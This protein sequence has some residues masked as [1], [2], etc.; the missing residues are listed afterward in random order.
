VNKDASP[1]K[2][3]NIVYFQVDNLGQGELGCY[4]GG[5]RRGAVTQRIDQFARD[6]L[7]LWH[8][9]T[10]PQCTPSRS[11][12][13]TGR[14]PIRS[15]THTVAIGGDEGG[16]VAW[17]RTLGDV[18]SDAGYATS[19]VGKWHIGAEPGRYPTDHGFDEWYGIPRSYDECLW[20]EDPRYDPKRDPVVYTLEGT[21]ESGIHE[22]K[23]QQ[24]TLEVRRTIDVEYE[25]RAFAFLR[26]S[27]ESE[28]P[29]FL[30]YNH[31]MMHL[32]NIPRDEFKGKSGYG[33]FADCLL[34]MDADFGRLL[35]LLDELNVAENT[36]VIFAGDNGPE[37]MLLHRGSPGLYDGSYFTSSEGG[38]R[39]PCIVRWPGRFPAGRESNEMVHISDMFTTLLSSVG[40]SAPADRII[41]GKDQAAFF[42][43]ETESS[44]RDGVIIWVGDQMHGVKWKDF[45]VL[46]KQ[47]RYFFDAAPP[48]GFIKIINLIKDP[49]EREPIDPEY[50]SS[51][52]AVHVGHILKEFKESV[53]REPVIP[54]G[55]PL[56]YVPK[57]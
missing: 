32:P 31:S 14:H 36:I 12:L 18:L 13:M 3:A 24:L 20:P 4:D 30:Y 48:L 25:R 21:K 41:D 22:R 6:G 53:A 38:L 42:R 29:F 17:E 49:K 50:Y 56:E 28:K 39:S 33:D 34:E 46:V 23:D 40:V 47:T 37:E 7:K 52:V 44:A 9:V 5:L 11:A 8:F 27:V 16:I 1:A 55:A 57:A 15:G 54:A 51:W 26:R 35:D 10:E 2:R 45:K 19:C 43:G